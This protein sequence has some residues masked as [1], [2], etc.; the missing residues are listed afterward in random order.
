MSKILAVN[1][2]SSSLKFKMFDMPEEVVLMEGLIDRIGLSDSNFKIEFN[3]QKIKEIHNI[4]DH[5]QAVSFLADKLFELGIIKNIDEIKGIGH[6]VV[7]GGER[8]KDSTVI[9]EEVINEIIKLYDIAPLHNPANVSGIKAFSEIFKSAKRVAVFDTSFHQTM[10]EEAYLYGTPYEWYQ[11]YGL[12]KYG[13]HGTSHKFVSQRAM[14]ILDNKE[15]KVIVCHLGNGASICAVDAGKSIDT[16]MGFT[17]LAGLVMGTR[18]GDIDPAIIPYIMNKTN[19]NINELETLLNKRSGLM[20]ISGS[21]S[22][23]RDIEENIKKGDKRSMLAQHMF[24]RR[25][26]SYVGMYHAMLG[27]NGAD[28]ICFTAGI[29]EN[30]VSTR[31][32]IIDRLSALGAYIDPELNNVRGQERLISTA[33]SKIKVYIIPTNEELVI[34]RDTYNNL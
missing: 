7:H 10:E 23:S 28:A 30:S 22:D 16:S 18:S 24:T 19:M 11:K 20:G 34:A 33:D 31:K 2:G 25:V 12:R 4:K 29:G 13:F 27:G 14:E 1:A 17:P 15:A 9:N 6:R 26:A 21:S 32:E 8:F 3:D 5:T